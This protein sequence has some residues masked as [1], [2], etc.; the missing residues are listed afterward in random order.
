MADA[1]HDVT[2]EEAVFVAHAEHPIGFAIIFVILH[3]IHMHDETFRPD[4]DFPF[5][6][7]LGREVV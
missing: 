1:A 3:G 5:V 6:A 2:A 4:F 7:N